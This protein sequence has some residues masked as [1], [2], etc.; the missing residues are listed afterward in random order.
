MPQNEKNECCCEKPDGLRGNPEEGTSVLSFGDK[1]EVDGLSVR[2]GKKPYR[3]YVVASSD[4]CSRK[5]KP[6]PNDMRNSRTAPRKGIKPKPDVERHK[7]A[8]DPMED[9]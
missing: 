2:Y 7:A 8:V 6:C 4:S 5:E 3:N 1:T 9:A